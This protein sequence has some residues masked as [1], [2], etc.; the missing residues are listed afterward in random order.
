MPDLK[1]LVCENNHMVFEV[2]KGALKT[3]SYTLHWAGDGRQAMEIMKQEAFDMVLTEIL[4]PFFSGLELIHMLRSKMNL[5]IPIVV[6]SLINTGNTIDLAFQLG[7]N[8]Y[9]PKPFA[10]EKLKNSITD[11]LLKQ[12][13]NLN[14]VIQ[15][16]HNSNLHF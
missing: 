4:L 9:L 16:Y 5:A 6:I 8:E 1:I 7:A 12:E 14:S 2:I 3:E 10:P 11:L 15:E 13:I